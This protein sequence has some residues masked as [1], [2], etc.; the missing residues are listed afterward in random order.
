MAE[1]ITFKELQ[2]KLKK[3][4]KFANKKTAKILNQAAFE[5]QKEARAET[6]KTFTLR[7]K[8]ALGAIQVKKATKKD[9]K[10][11]IGSTA[12]YQEYHEFGKPLSRNIWGQSLTINPIATLSGRK[13]K[14]TN[15][16]PNEYR[17]N[18]MGN[19]RQIGEKIKEGKLKKRDKRFFILK[20]KGKDPAI[21]E[22]VG[23]KRHDIKPIRI[24]SRKKKIRKRSIFKNSAKNVIKSNDI[25]KN[26]SYEMK[27]TLEI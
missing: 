19:I 13:N 1:T 14:Y 23:T 20:P 8:Y 2:E 3:L 10:S 27:K 4:E 22:R 21:Y 7:N 17:L 18:K 5:V 6:E 26:I 15:I 9:K 16:I 25:F 24:L 12:E 11:I